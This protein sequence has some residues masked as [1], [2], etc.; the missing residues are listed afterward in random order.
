LFGSWPLARY[1]HG[2]AYDSD[3]HRMVIFGGRNGSSALFDDAWE[4]DGARKQWFDRADAVGG[5]A[6]RAGPAMA[7]DPVRKQTFPFGGWQPAGNVYANAQW[8]WD[9]PTATWQQRTSNSG[10]PSARYGHAMV[11]DSDRQRIVMFG[12]FGGPSR[13]RLNDIWEW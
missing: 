1:E 6:E 12:G 11:W 8:E 2:L 13:V 4:W 5:P 9:G 10:Q 3:R 7:Y